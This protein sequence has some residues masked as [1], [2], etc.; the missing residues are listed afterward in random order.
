MRLDANTT[1]VATVVDSEYAYI[2]TFLKFLEKL[3]DI[4]DKMF[5]GLIEKIG[6]LMN[7]LP[8]D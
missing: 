6:Q 8:Q 4:M 5:G 7:V 1:D 2:G 3:V